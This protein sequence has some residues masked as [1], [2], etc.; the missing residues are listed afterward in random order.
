MGS[1]REFWLWTH[2][3]A[4]GAESFV[5]AAELLFPVKIQ[6]PKIKVFKQ[7]PSTSWA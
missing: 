6:P 2:L 5:L 7:F 1:C 4:T 3:A